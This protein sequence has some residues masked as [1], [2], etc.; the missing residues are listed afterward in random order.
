MTVRK[1]AKSNFSGGPVAK[2]LPASAEDTGSI[3]GLRKPGCPGA[4]NPVHRTTEPAHL[5]PAVCNERPLHQEA[6]GLQLEKAKAAKKAQHGHKKIIFFK[7][8]NNPYLG[9]LS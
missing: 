2:N 5:E 3:P 7:A 6:H 8:A 4:T 1:A 9:H